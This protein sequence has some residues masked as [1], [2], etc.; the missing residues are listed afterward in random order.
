MLAR[1][2]PDDGDDSP[3]SAGTT[4]CEYGIG[5]EMCR[6]MSDLSA[7]RDKL[8]A[9]CVEKV[10]GGYSGDRHLLEDMNIL[11]SRY[12]ILGCRQLSAIIVH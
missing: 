3:F 5:S 12:A 2:S 10:F 1:H 7:H 8:Q 4:D 9:Q 11:I 6:L